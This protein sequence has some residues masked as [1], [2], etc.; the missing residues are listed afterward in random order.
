[1]E[2]PCEALCSSIPDF[3]SG[4]YFFLAHSSLAGVKTVE[5]VL[6]FVYSIRFSLLQDLKRL[7]VEHIQK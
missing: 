6:A 4:F 3:R 2:V 7:W 1:M 5:E